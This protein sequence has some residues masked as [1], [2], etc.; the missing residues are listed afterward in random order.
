MSASLRAARVRVPGSTSNL[1]SGFDVLGLAVDRYLDVRFEPDDGGTVRL[2]R[3]GLL[4]RLDGLAGRDLIEEAFSTRLA[5]AGVRASGVLR[6]CSE[7]PIGR[8]LGSSAAA[9]VAGF[10]L[11]R[12]ALGL[13]SDPDEAFAEV[14]R[15]EGHGDNGAP[16]VWGGLR[17]C[18]PGPEGPRVLELALDPSVGFAYAAPSA[19]LATAEARAALPASVPHATA[20]R[21]L[22]RILALLRGLERGDPQLVRTGIEDELHVPH[23]LPL[24]PGGEAALAA[25]YAAGAWGVTISG[26]GTG[27]LAICAADDAERVAEAM[28]A[29]FGGE[30]DD[31]ER[32]GFA[33]RPDPRGMR[34]LEMSAQD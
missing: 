14:Y 8:G 6:A 33:I 1:G 26:A 2:E 11:A 34:R 3:T 10:D 22:G 7:I 18:V 25:G 24:I 29:A 27:L 23:R 19:L 5:A 9:V 4:R 21:G 31:P 28:R 30:P 32:V 12:A 15:R 16:S 20:V 17:A 13:P